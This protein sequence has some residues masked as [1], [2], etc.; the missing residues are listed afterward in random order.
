[1]EKKEDEEKEVRRE[2]NKKE[3]AHIHKNTFLFS[4]L[5]P[6][7]LPFVPQPLRVHAPACY[8]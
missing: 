2:N 8:A 1:M 4:L 3:I 5:P 6:S 7:P